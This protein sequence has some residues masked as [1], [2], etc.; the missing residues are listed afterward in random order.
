MPGL[1]RDLWVSYNKL[2]E[3]AE[4]GGDVERHVRLMTRAWS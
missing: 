2:G 4:A 3:V 1:K